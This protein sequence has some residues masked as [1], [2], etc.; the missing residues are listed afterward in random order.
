MINRFHSASPSTVALST[1]SQ[2]K[3]INAGDGF[4]E[5]LNALV[6]PLLQ[7]ERQTPESLPE[8]E[9][10]DVEMLDADIPFHVLIG[11]T[12]S[13][14]GLAAVD[15]VLEPTIPGTPIDSSLPKPTS[16]PA[17]I[18]LQPITGLLPV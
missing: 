15:N 17:L 12:D 13:F 5:M 6:S 3:K 8:E 14:V 18:P 1:G 4:G 10:I 9:N 11:N 7:T 16:V 2:A